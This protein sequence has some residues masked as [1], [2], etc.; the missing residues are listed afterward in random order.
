M[1]RDSEA[2]KAFIMGRDKAGFPNS[3]AAE[4]ERRWRTF[5]KIIPGLIRTEEI[6]AVEVSKTNDGALMISLFDLYGTR[7][8]LWCGAY[9]ISKKIQVSA[10]TDY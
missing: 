5:A 1:H 4:R 3:T 7:T 10:I 2:H 8:T 6:T 9:G